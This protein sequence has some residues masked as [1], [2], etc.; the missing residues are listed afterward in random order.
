MNE[1]AEYDRNGLFPVHVYGWAS[2]HDHIA[3]AMAVEKISTSAVQGSNPEEV[4]SALHSSFVGVGPVDDS[5]ATL[6]A[7]ALQKA[8]EEKGRVGVGAGCVC[9]RGV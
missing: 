2:N 1:K 7:A 4:L 9:T 3:V 5:C 8:V 6:Y